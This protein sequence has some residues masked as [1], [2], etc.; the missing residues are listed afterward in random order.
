[1][2]FARRQAPVRWSLELAV[3]L[4]RPLTPYVTDPF[5]PACDPD[6]ID[7]DRSDEALP[8]LKTFWRDETGAT[9]IEYALI[10]ALISVAI[11]TLVTA[12]GTSLRGTLNYIAV[13]IP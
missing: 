1:V 10:A 7:R 3:A 2:R 13:A 11:V 5:T 4:R 9:A 8:C 12:L 6:A